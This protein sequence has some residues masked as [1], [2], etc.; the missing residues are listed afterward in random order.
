MQVNWANLGKQELI[1]CHQ[2]PASIPGHT[3]PWTSRV[4]NAP[5]RPKRSQHRNNPI[6]NPTHRENLGC[7]TSTPPA[8]ALL[9]PGRRPFRAQQKTPPPHTNQ[10][11]PSKPPQQTCSAKHLPE[12]PNL[13]RRIST[14]RAPPNALALS[15][16]RH[17]P[18][19]TTALNIPPKPPN[20][21]PK[22]ALIRCHNRCNPPLSVPHSRVTIGLILCPVSPSNPPCLP[23]PWP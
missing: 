11:S 5:S 3:S 18:K 12:Q 14:K 4:R 20:P 15:F 21:S 23:L 6:R 16:P 2:Y 17:R 19:F 1:C 13:A 10:S 9:V 22:T 8:N 7:L